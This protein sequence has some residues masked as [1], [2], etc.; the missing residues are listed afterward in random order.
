MNKTDIAGIIFKELQDRGC[1]AII[2]YLHSTPAIIV[3]E[4][5]SIKIIMRIYVGFRYITIQRSSDN[6]INHH[7]IITPGMEWLEN[8]QR[9]WS[10][11]C[12]VLMSYSKN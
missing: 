6:S 2:S 8:N 4:P 3:F 12:V 10:F 7:D 1:N 11:G 9:I 5:L